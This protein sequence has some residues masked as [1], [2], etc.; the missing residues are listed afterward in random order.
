M[1]RIA[2]FSAAIVCSVA[3]LLSFSSKKKAE[4]IVA[5]P[6]AKPIV[7]CAPSEAGVN[8]V[9]PAEFR[10]RFGAEPLR[11]R[12]SVY[13]LT[14]AEINAIKVG[15]LK[16]RALPYTDP[17]SWRYQAAIHGTTMSDN[18]PSW[19]TCH[20]SG[21]ADFFLLWHRMYVYFFERIMRAKS[22][23]ANIAQPYWNYQLNAVMPPAYRDNSPSNPLYDGTRTSTINNGGA[24]PSS[25]MTAFNTSLNNTDFYTFQ[26]N[27]N[28]GPHG[29]VHTSINGNMAV[30][31]SAAQ[32]PVFM[33]HH[34]NIDRLWEEWRSRCGGRVNPTDAAWM[35][36]I[37]T[38]FDE[39]GTAVSM[40]GSDIIEI[41]TQLNYRYDDREPVINC[42]GAR[43]V[44]RT[45]QN[46]VTKEVSVA[47][48]G[49]ELKT[50]FSDAAATNLETLMR[51]EN[52]RDFNF[53]GTNISERLVINFEG[54][55]IQRMPQGVI[56]VYLNLPAGQRPSAS[57][58][59][60]VGLFDLFSVEHHATHGTAD[61]NANGA[62]TEMDATH[63]AKEL[64][65]TLPELRNATLSFY[66]RGAT[67]RGVE[68]PADAQISI[69]RI[70]FTLEKQQVQ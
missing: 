68:A 3:L 42:A 23:R 18:L 50:N 10:K 60:F 52:R 45:R 64:G 11:T 4:A 5:K 53:T 37:Y 33:L 66:V 39:T 6:I 67:L 34:G 56:E 59:Y 22:G 25:I 36:R 48:V 9:T 20:K 15:I 43:P 47:V 46:L 31:S 2:L 49:K 40:R 26:T 28:N 51:T 62:S 55:N 19:N 13:A 16:M 57:S 29:S 27:M 35:N 70:K 69:Q 41:S 24:L 21:E 61:E 54:V 12:K 63:A 30:V 8:L 7:D 58:K 44:A 38:F 14:Q 32:D 1:K 17:T 65:L